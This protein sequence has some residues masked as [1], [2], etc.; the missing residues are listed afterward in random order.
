MIKLPLSNSSLFYYSV[1]ILTGIT[2]NT[3]QTDGACQ[4][5]L[6]IV[7]MDSNI[8]AWEPLDTA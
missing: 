1:C 4:G 8:H 5:N 2:F 7:Q 3:F 6:Q